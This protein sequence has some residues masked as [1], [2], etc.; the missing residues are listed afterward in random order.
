MKKL[1]LLGMGAILTL[2]TATVSMA[3]E[4]LELSYSHVMNSNHPASKG[5]A[6][7]AAGVE[8][9][10]SGQIVIHVYDNSS[11]MKTQEYIPAM[12]A[13]GLDMGAMYASSLFMDMPH[14]ATH[15]LPFVANDARDASRLYWQMLQLPEAQAEIGK[16]GIIITGWSS[17]RSCLASIKNP[18]LKPSDLKGKR[19]LV[20]NGPYAEEVRVWGGIPV[21]VTPQDTYIALQRGMGEVLYGQIPMVP[22]LKLQELVKHLTIMPSQNNAMAVVLSKKTAELM[23]P[24]LVQ[25]I[26]DAG[27]QKESERLANITYEAS[28]RD[29]TLL[30]E[31]GVQVHE[32]SP[33]DLEEFKK[34]S[35]SVLK[36]FWLDVLTK[37]GEPNGEAWIE[38]IYAMSEQTK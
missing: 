6:E 8:E 24:E 32:L 19:V 13:G 15:S 27:G 14:L 33:T 28:E 23:S 12:K 26:L 31:A 29:L 20:W 2:T 3:E 30:K 25:V 10:S 18:I 1:L 37:A 21:L 4:Y 38:K 16:F 17:D 34:L 35:I 11:L 36:P 22:S 9:K 5:I 7:W